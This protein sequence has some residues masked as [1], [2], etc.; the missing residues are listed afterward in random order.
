MM[1]SRFLT[2]PTPLLLAGTFSI[3]AFHT[4]AKDPVKQPNILMIVVDDMNGYSIRNEYPLIKT[5]YLDK[6]KSEG[7]NF[8]HAYCSTPVCNP[9]R[10][11]F[12]SGLYPHITGAYLNGSDGWNRSEILK[13]IYNFP[14][15]LKLNGYET[16]G[17]GK[18][19]HNPISPEREKAMWDNEKV[20]QGGF[21][22]FPEE[23]YWTEGRFFSVKP[24]TGP[25]S[26]F[27]DV[28]NADSSI[29]FLSRDHEKPFLLYYGLWRPHCPY[30][31]PQRFFD[32][33]NESEFTLP[34]GF[35]QDDLDDVPYLGTMLVDSLKKFKGKQEDFEKLWKR[36]IYGYAANYSFADWNAGRVIEALDNS[37]YADNTIVIFFS[38]NG[39]HCGEKMRWEKATLWE[40]SDYV[41]LIIR[42][43][44]K[45]GKVCKATVNLADIYPTLVDLCK[46]PR[47][48]HQLDGKSMVPLLKDVNKK[49]NRPSFTSYGVE[50]ASVRD[51]RY[52]YIRYPDG[53]EELYDDIKDPYEWLNIASDPAIKQVKKRLEKQIPEKWAPCLGGRLEVLRDFDKV[54]REKSKFGGPNGS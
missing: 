26:D 14:E 35:R 44:E 10:S 17:N 30:N 13:S 27:P 45:R 50:Y 22:P 12:F 4:M 2:H 16:F 46:I 7:I 6:L 48:E 29:E 25:D 49:W 1:N 34:E 43:P 23:E 51:S 19:L 8:V 36:F 18:I 11:S 28:K 38:D 20:F 37:R 31:A 33:Y 41:P 15:W 40:Q 9:S 32:L 5:P 39:Y 53:K 52:R 24:W 54:M 47:P 42:T 21:G 3:A